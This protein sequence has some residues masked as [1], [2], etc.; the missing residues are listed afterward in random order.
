MN[1][2]T[3][4]IMPVAWAMV[5]LVI[6]IG[7]VLAVV[8]TAAK[9]KK[10]AAS[11]L[12]PRNTARLDFISL[13]IGMIPR[14]ADSVKKNPLAVGWLL[15][16][17]LLPTKPS[18]AAMVAAAAFFGCGFLRKCYA[19]GTCA[20]RRIDSHSSFRPFAYSVA[21]DAESDGAVGQ[22]ESVPVLPG[23]EDIISPDD[24]VGLPDTPD[25]PQEPEPVTVEEDD[26]A[27]MQ[28]FPDYMGVAVGTVP[29]NGNPEDIFHEHITIA[30]PADEV[31]AAL[32]RLTK[33][34]KEA[35]VYG[36]FDAVRDVGKKTSPLGIKRVQA[37]YWELVIPFDDIHDEFGVSPDEFM[38]YSMEERRLFIEKNLSRR[39]G[40]RAAFIAICKSDSG[41]LHIHIIVR[42]WNCSSFDVVKNLINEGAHINAIDG[43]G[44][45]NVIDYLK[46]T[47]RHK[48]KKETIFTSGGFGDI[49]SKRGK[50]N[51]IVAIREDIDKGY[52]VEEIFERN[53]GMNVT[54][55]MSLIRRLMQGASD[56]GSTRKTQVY[57]VTGLV[58][59]GKTASVKAELDAAGIPYRLISGDSSL[60]MYGGEDAII[61][62]NP[63]P[64]TCSY[65][66]IMRCSGTEVA[67]I[68]VRYGHSKTQMKAVYITTN[69]SPED[70]ATRFSWNKDPHALISYIGVYRYCFRVISEHEKPGYLQ[71][72]YDGRTRW[73]R[74]DHVDIQV[75]E[76]AYRG[77]EDLRRLATAYFT[78]TRNGLEYAEGLEDVV[79]TKADLKAIDTIGLEVNEYGAVVTP[80]SFISMYN[81]V[82]A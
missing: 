9:S 45:K 51:D 82:L 66:T 8:L 52:N 33:A 24:P 12:V 36:R 63:T 39:K 62:E 64:E 15:S 65:D 16:A 43:A 35:G 70:F 3:A 38:D 69:L 71:E 34:S 60:E 68:K 72:R 58:G 28:L 59:S 23:M 21:G 53:P 10:K 31:P 61:I 42:F 44:V 5:A 4:L 30:I 50:R 13:D 73:V 79:L 54:E 75:T 80:D 57:F 6:A 17:M 40:V 18:V 67:D 74:Y 27:Q 41:Y 81:N 2:I 49:Y 25:I 7:I 20:E 76:H 11:G 19:F 26:P 1:G 55:R 22:N 48:E 32:E 37:H 56:T 78:A 77:I 14:L 46:K 29:W 47:G